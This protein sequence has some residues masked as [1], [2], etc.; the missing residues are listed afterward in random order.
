M[1][2]KTLGTSGKLLLREML[3]E[4]SSSQTPTERARSLSLLS[5]PHDALDVA[6]LCTAAIAALPAEA[7]AFRNGR[8]NVLNKILG[9]VMKESRGRADSTEVRERLVAL[10]EQGG[11]NI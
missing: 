4:P 3:S 8:K 2:Y 9:W 1:A 7:L 5:A 6:D 11:D 10:L